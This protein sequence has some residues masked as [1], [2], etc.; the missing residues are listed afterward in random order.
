MLEQE[1]TI[2]WHD[3]PNDN[4]VAWLYKHTDA[5]EVA[6]E[7]AAVPVPSHAGKPRL[8]ALFI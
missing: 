7:P 8:I 5:L 1:E 3:L 6:S 2:V 4:I